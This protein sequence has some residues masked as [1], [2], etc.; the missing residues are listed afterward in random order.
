[1]CFHRPIYSRSLLHNT[2]MGYM[3]STS[4]P[5]GPCSSTSGLPPH[6]TIGRRSRTCSDR[7]IKPDTWGKDA[8][9][10]EVL[11]RLPCGAYG[12]RT[13]DLLRDRQA[14]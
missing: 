10:K 12:T 3:D 7:F 1:M 4:P 13:R 11:L 5:A 14:F 9:K 2:N 8:Q 6:H